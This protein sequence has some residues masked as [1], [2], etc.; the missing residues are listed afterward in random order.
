MILKEELREKK[1]VIFHRKVY[2]AALFSVALIALLLWRFSNWYYDD[3]FITYRYAWNLIHGNGFVYNP[4]ERVLS[5]TTPFFTLLLAGLGIIW[6]NIPKIAVILGCIFIGLS[7]L[8]FWDLAQQ[9]KLTIAGWVGLVLLPTFPLVTSTIGSE[10]PLYIALV[11]GSLDLFMRR[12]YNWMALL[13]AI[14]SLVR[15]DGILLPFVIGIYYFVKNKNEIPWGAIGIFISI[16]FL[17]FGFAWYY[18]GFPLPAT[19]MVK[20]QQGVMSISQHFAPGLLTIAKPYTNKW[21]YIVEIVLAFIGFVWI[22]FRRNL[23]LLL[24]SWTLFYFLAY[25]ILGVTRY[26]W[27]YAPLIPSFIL[28]IGV[29]FEIIIKFF[30]QALITQFKVIRFENILFGALFVVCISQGYNTYQYS[31]TPDSRYDIYHSIGEWLNTNT[32]KNDKVGALEV[33][34]IGYYADRPMIDFAGLIEPDVAKQMQTVYTYED[35]ALWAIN[36]YQPSYV[37]L[38][39]T[40]FSG[41]IEKY[42]TVQCQIVKDFHKDDFNSNQDMIIFYCN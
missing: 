14:L 36:R 20:Q 11:L 32:A 18:F 12:H 7:G 33:G 21:Y 29:G 23:S 3:P 37:V 24:I 1:N 25:T 4:G 6:P 42:I 31:Q 40:A 28:M 17:W 41:L 27:Y 19:L 26:F 15:P 39:P 10:T 30:K 8:I 16:N 34:I 38:N 35:T 13:M 22:I 9:W 2:I 5:T